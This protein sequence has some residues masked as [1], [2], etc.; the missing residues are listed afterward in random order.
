MGM[1]WC[2]LLYHIITVTN[3]TSSPTQDFDEERKDYETARHALFYTDENCKKMYK[4]HVKTIIERRNMVNGRLYKDDPTILGWSL[5]NEPRCETW[6]VTN[7]V[8]YLQ[9]WLEEMSAYVK[10]LDNRHLLTIGEEG[11]FAA[12]SPRAAANPAS[13]GILMGQNFT[14]NHMI[15]EIDFVTVHVWPDNWNKYDE[16]GGVGGWGGVNGCICVFVLRVSLYLMTIIPHTIPHTSPNNIPHVQQCVQHLYFNLHAVQPVLNHHH[17][18]PTHPPNSYTF[19][20]FSEWVNAHVDETTE[21]LQKPLVMTE[22][23]KKMY[24]K[25]R[26]KEIIETR[27]PV[28]RVAYRIFLDNMKR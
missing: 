22:F 21:L 11:F 10:S 23:G 1:Q 7:C 16:D 26:K 5:I 14:G 17:Q 6:K 18:T 20:F 24:T 15:P 27:D 8:T 4:N 13:W 19:E 28:Y 9:K 3:T 2:V 25:D 12:G